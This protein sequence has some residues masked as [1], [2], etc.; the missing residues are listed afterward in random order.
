ME[1]LAAA[2]TEE[3]RE[4]LARPPEGGLLAV[5]NSPSSDTKWRRQTPMMV[6]AASGAFAVFNTLLSAIDRAELEGYSVRI[7]HSLQGFVAS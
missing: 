1:A 3:V 7:T 6:A 4:V 5:L 2:G